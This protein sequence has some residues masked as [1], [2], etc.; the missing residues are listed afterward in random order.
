MRAKAEGLKHFC[1]DRKYVY[2]ETQ[3]DVWEVHVRGRQ[4]VVDAGHGTYQVYD[5]SGRP[6]YH[7]SEHYIT[8]PG[9]GFYLVRRKGQT[10]C[11][12]VAE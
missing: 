6:V 9:K 11:V 5:L 8:L 2:T 1:K 12:S 4:L 7:G 3:E 10:R